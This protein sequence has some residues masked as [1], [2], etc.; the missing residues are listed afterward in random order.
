MV[1]K[2]GPLRLVERKLLSIQK[3]KSH[4]MMRQISDESSGTESGGEESSKHKR[5]KVEDKKVLLY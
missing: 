2:K 5:T 4:K 1:G 3:R